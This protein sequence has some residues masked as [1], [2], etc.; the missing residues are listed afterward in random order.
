MLA[1][2]SPKLT[3]LVLVGVPLTVAPLLLFGR[4]VRKFSRASQDRLAE[5]ASYIDETLH[6]IRTVQAHRHEGP[7]GQRSMSES[8][9]PSL[10]LC[11]ASG[12]AH[13]LPRW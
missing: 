2:T 1:I 12:S 5:V 4:R 8:R 11:A 7:A 10:R 9:R 3:L 6:E 13:C